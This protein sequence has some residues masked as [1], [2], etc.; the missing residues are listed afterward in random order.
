[1]GQP[2]KLECFDIEDT[3]SAVVLLPESRLEE[4]RLQAFDSGY[5]A[6]WDD[7]AAAHVS[8]QANISEV[9][10][11]NLQRM[12]FTYHEARAAILSEMEAILRGMV[13]RI[14][15]S[16]LQPSLGEMI[17]DRVLEVSQEAAEVPVEIVIA[18]EN[19][20]RLRQIVA[21][22]VAPPL[23]IREE[24]SLGGG[25]A[26]LRIGRTEE[27]VDLDSVL[28]EISAAVTDFFEC[29]TPEKEA[30]NA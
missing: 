15:P 29:G 10:A 26:F 16:A 18:P 4:E 23:D 8:Q 22:K 21:G 14:L 24:V 2:L 7:A 9:L 19:A 25:Q 13:E 27:K 20:E 28:L 3:A 1:M 12:S 5:K 11:D 17:L 30:I 6:G